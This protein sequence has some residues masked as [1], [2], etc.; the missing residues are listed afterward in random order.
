MLELPRNPRD[1]L[2][3]DK[4]GQAALDAHKA[5]LVA[6]DSR[7]RVIWPDWVQ[8]FEDLNEPTFLFF[9]KF[10]GYLKKKIRAAMPI[11]DIDKHTLREISRLKRQR[12]EDAVK[13]ATSVS[14]GLFFKNLS[15]NQSLRSAIGGM[16]KGVEEIILL[17]Q[18][19]LPGQ[20]AQTMQ[21][22]LL[23]SIEPAQEAA[24]GNDNDQD[25]E[26]T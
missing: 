9:M 10:A 2:I 4:R 20:E 5:S 25:R 26:R 15:R 3:L 23:P 18:V 8:T 22:M 6:R 17:R 11:N 16:R 12:Y 21:N 19:R 1:R 7:G 13:V 14:V 24:M